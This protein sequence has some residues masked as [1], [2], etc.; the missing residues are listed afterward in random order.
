MFSDEQEP[1][2]INHLKAHR[3]NGNLN[4]QLEKS[5]HYLDN[6]NH[7]DD[8]ERLQYLRA[9]LVTKAVNDQPIKDISEAINVFLHSA[10][11]QG[12]AFYRHPNTSLKLLRGILMMKVQYGLPVDDVVKAMEAI[13][14]SRTGFAEDLF[15]NVIGSPQK[16]LYVN[17]PKLSVVLSATL[18]SILVV[19][20]LGAFGLGC[21]R[22]GYVVG[23][24]PT[25]YPVIRKI[26]E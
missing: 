12:H 8:R 25:L 22:I 6:Y 14:N 3:V 17:A 4:S 11:C 24:Q 2:N 19:A 5:V 18:A 1:Q 26:I 10:E 23:R 16:Y 9:A 15:W 21:L 7:G 13:A 20:G